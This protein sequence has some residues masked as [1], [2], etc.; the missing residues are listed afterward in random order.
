MSKKLIIPIF[1][2]VLILAA[3]Y[4]F[5]YRL[6]QTEYGQILDTAVNYQAIIEEES[7]LMD[8]WQTRLKKKKGN[9]LWVER[10]A[11]ILTYRLSSISEEAEAIKVNSYFGK[12]SKARSKLQ[13]AIAENK[14]WL[15]FL[16]GLSSE[17]VPGRLSRTEYRQY[18][19]HSA[20]ASAAEDSMAAILSENRPSPDLSD[21][22]R[23]LAEMKKDFEAFP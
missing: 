2:I 5:G 7:D 15:V 23:T 18:L 4:A 3:F 8:V 13:L 9:Y 14:K 16:T 20:D 1:V 10:R 21:T 12:L 17:A 11:S 6:Y 22:R 19:I